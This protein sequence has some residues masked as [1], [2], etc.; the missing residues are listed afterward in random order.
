MIKAQRQ[1]FN[2]TTTKTKSTTNP[3]SKLAAEQVAEMVKARLPSQSSS[4][5]TPAKYSKLYIVCHYPMP[6]SN[7]HRY[8]IYQIDL[9]CTKTLKPP[10]PAPLNPIIT[11][12]QSFPNDMA[13]IVLLGHLLLFGGDSLFV[14]QGTRSSGRLVKKRIEE[15]VITWT[16]DMLIFD[17]TKSSKCLSLSTSSMV[18]GPNMKSPKIY[19][20][21]VILDEVKICVFSLCLVD[22][23]GVQLQH[24]P[25]NFEVYNTLTGNWSELPEPFDYSS[26]VSINSYVIGKSTLFIS[27]E[28]FGISF[29]DIRNGIWQ[30]F[31][32]SPKVARFRFHSYGVII[33]SLCLLSKNAY[34]I[35]NMDSFALLPKSE[36]NDLVPSDNHGGSVS[37][38]ENDRF[39]TARIGFLGVSSTSELLGDYIPHLFVDVYEY[40]KGRTVAMTKVTRVDT[41]RYFVTD[42]KLDIAAAIG[43]FPACF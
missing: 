11:L 18:K 9:T 22:K 13:V 24:Y 26:Q 23:S 17:F 20:A 28:C 39:V 41:F 34:D 16:S 38:M 30:K 42:Q 21:A 25:P 3:K 1:K 37:L 4:G 27:T 7:P 35:Q 2:Q 6:Y 12:D 19:P 29:I 31:D 33:D 43:C 10:S 40:T 8:S 14:K 5:S 32:C 15:K 36:T